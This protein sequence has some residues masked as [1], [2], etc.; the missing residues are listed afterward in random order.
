MGTPGEESIL[1]RDSDCQLIAVNKVWKL[2]S[3]HVDGRIAD[4]TV[5]RA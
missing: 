5:V 3:S 2:L 4:N 1:S